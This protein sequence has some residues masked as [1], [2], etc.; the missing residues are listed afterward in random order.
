MSFT[1][2]R[3][4]DVAPPKP[5]HTYIRQYPSSHQEIP[6][7]EGSGKQNQSGDQQRHRSVYHHGIFAEIP[8]A[9]HFQHPGFCREHIIPAVL[10]TQEHGK[11]ISME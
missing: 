8:F 5:L 7:H 6:S 2:N 10:R 9:E 4:V 11:R 1:Y 3:A